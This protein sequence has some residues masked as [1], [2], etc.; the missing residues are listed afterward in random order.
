MSQGLEGR[1]DSDLPATEHMAVCPCRVS[2]SVQSFF[3]A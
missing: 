2:P 3:I 1:C